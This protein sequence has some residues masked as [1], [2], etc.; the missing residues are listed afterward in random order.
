MKRFTAKE[1]H[2][3]LQC[4]IYFSNRFPQFEKIST[5]NKINFIDGSLIEMPEHMI[6]LNGDKFMGPR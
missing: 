3:R 6:H 2:R 1:E 5:Q 4:S